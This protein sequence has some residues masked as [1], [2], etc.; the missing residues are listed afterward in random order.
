MPLGTKPALAIRRRAATLDWLVDVKSLAVSQAVTAAC[1]RRSATP[2]RRQAAATTMSDTKPCPKKPWS[3]HIAHD[4][5]GVDRDP[6]LSLFDG[7]RDLP[8]ARDPPEA[9]ASTARMAGVS[10]GVATRT[11]CAS[12]GGAV[13]SDARVGGAPGRT[14]SRIRLRHLLRAAAATPPAARA[15]EAQRAGV[16]CHDADAPGARMGGEQRARGLR[17][18]APRGSRA[19]RR[20]RPFRRRRCRAVAGPGRSLRSGPARGSDRK[21]AGFGPIQ[22]QI[23]VSGRPRPGAQVA[24]QQGGEFLR[25]GRRRERVR[26]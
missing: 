20:T 13:W 10:A 11:C 14:A 3:H 15:P 1:S 23:R 12:W 4:A 8:G 18:Q 5:A 7:P 19:A 6:A 2:W 16:V 24:G 17:A 21:A 22:Q 9:R 25:A 26:A